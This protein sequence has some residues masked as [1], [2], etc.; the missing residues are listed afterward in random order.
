MATRPERSTELQSL[1]DGLAERRDS[2]PDWADTEDLARLHMQS[3]GRKVAGGFD[4]FAS[5]GR[6][7]LTGAGVHGHSIDLAD[8]GELLTRWQ[9]LVT[10]TGGAI[11]GKTSTRK[12]PDAIRRRTKLFL[13]ASPG[14][15]SVILEFAPQVDEPAERYPGGETTFDGDEVALVQRS[16]NAAMDIL[17]LASH[18]KIDLTASLAGWGPRVASKALELAELAAAAQLDLELTWEETG[19]ARRRGQTTARQFAQFATMLKAESLDTER[20]SFAGVLRTISDRKKIDLDVADAKS[21]ASG[22][23]VSIARGKVDFSDFR[24]GESVVIAA[25]VK[26]KAKPGGREGR[27]YT[28]ESV[29]AVTPPAG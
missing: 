14:A 22:R 9:D 3:F 29:T 2:F 18:D 6:I 28:A 10:S 15:G 25:T 11:E 13:T 8:T 7:R 16:V 26:L 23:V 5:R 19:K 24:I 20:I 4:V 1:L 12:L 27:S 21:P 17:D